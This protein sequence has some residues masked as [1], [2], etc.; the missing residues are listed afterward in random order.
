MILDKP[1]KD[2]DYDGEMDDPGINNVKVELLSESGY[3]VN[4]SENLLLILM[5]SI[6]LLMK[7]PASLLMIQ[8]VI[9]P[10]QQRVRYLIQPK[11]M[12]TDIMIYFI[13][14]NITPGSY[15]LRYIFLKTEE[16]DEYALTTRFF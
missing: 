14:S 8:P 15:K 1:S 4:R 9:L 3:P 12:F 2:V 6:I 7:L 16:Y 13:I 10:L 5:V 11:R